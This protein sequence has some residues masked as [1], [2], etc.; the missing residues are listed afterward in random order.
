MADDLR[1]K[2]LNGTYLPGQ[3]LPHAQALMEEYQLS[4]QNT[5]EQ[6]YKILK[7]G[8]DSPQRCRGH[9]RASAAQ[10]VSCR[11]GSVSS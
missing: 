10:A 6:V 4:S 1:A 2:I 3:P 8:A 5:L 9:D 11:S 7:G